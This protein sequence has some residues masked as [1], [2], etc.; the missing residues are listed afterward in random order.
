MNAVPA[1][2][3]IFARVFNPHKAEYEFDQ[4]LLKA[5]AGGKFL[6][7]P[8]GME[9]LNNFN[10][11]PGQI[12]TLA[13]EADRVRRQFG[14]E[15]HRVQ[16]WIDGVAMVADPRGVLVAAYSLPG[17]AEVVSV[18]EPRFRLVDAA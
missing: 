11:Q 6:N 16:C 7:G 2:G 13:P 1:V 5:K 4:W 8:C 3:E 14:Y 15:S 12:Q 10:Y 18:E 17:F 9:I